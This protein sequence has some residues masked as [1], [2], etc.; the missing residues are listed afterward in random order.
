MWV[1][2]GGRGLKADELCRVQAIP[3]VTDREGK[4]HTQTRPQLWESHVT[5]GARHPSTVPATLTGRPVEAL[6]PGPHPRGTGH[7]PSHQAPLKEFLLPFFYNLGFGDL[8]TGPNGDFLPP[9]SCHHLM[10]SSSSPLPALRPSSTD[11][12]LVH[13]I[14][15]GSVHILKRTLR[16]SVF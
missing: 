7:S 10:L 14:N 6:P 5:A 1:W 9:T 11:G 4:K 3:E 2:S 8:R 12:T 13:Y 15:L 16:K